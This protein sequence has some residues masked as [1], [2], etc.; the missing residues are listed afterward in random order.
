MLYSLEGTGELV[1]ILQST[2]NA[3][4]KVQANKWPLALNSRDKVRH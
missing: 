4:G 2:Y 1:H 3:N